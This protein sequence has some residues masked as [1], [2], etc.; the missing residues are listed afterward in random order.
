MWQTYV[1]NSDSPFS[2]VIQPS[3]HSPLRIRDLVGRDNW[4]ENKLPKYINSGINTLSC[5]QMYMF[6]FILLIF[7]IIIIRKGEHLLLHVQLYNITMHKICIALW[8]PGLT[9]L[10]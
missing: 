7:G 1:F 5:T 3:T 10:G 9:S 4:Y 8:N 6:V 2:T